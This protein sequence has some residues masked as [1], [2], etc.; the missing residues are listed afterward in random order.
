MEGVAYAFFSR[1]PPPLLHTEFL[2]VALGYPGTRSVDH[3]S[4]K[5]KDPLAP[6]S[7]AL[8]ATTWPSKVSHFLKGPD[9]KYFRLLR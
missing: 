6:A 1:L 2:S 9:G 8:A 5:L 7:P 3:A 4:L